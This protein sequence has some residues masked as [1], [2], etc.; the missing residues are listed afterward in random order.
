MFDGISILAFQ[1]RAAPTGGGL[2]PPLRIVSN[3]QHQKEREALMTRRHLTGPLTAAIAFTLI[4]L[5]TAQRGAAPAA[6]S[7]ATSSAASNSDMHW[8]ATWA[9]AQQQVGAARGGGGRGAGGG[10]G[11]GAAGQAGGAPG[12][13][14]APAPAP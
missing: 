11:R 4:P 6:A 12:A 8:V 5:A 1:R 3:N 2:T 10:G 13:A 7:A 14:P 9:S